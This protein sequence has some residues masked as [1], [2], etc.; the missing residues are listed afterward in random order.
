MLDGRY[1]R[2]RRRQRY[3]CYPPGTSHSFV[4]SVPRQ[5]TPDNQCPACERPFGS[6]REG[7]QG[8]YEHRYTAREIAQALIA[9]GRGDSYGHTARTLRREHGRYRRRGLT[10]YLAPDATLVMDWV[11]VFAPVLERALLAQSWP[12]QGL[13]QQQASRFPAVLVDDVPFHVRAWK[14]RDGATRT[15]KQS[16]RRIFAILGAAYYVGDRM[17][18]LRL[19]AVPTATSEARWMELL[20]IVPHQ[21]YPP[22][23]VLSDEAVGLSGAIRRV[24]PDTTVQ[25][26]CVYHLRAQLERI[27]YDAGLTTP[28]RR[29][30]FAGIRTAFQPPVANW[31]VWAARARALHIPRLHAWLRRKEQKVRRQVGWA[32][33]PVSSGA[34]ELALQKVKGMLDRRRWAYRNQKRMDRLLA[35]IALHLNE[36]DSEVVY[37][38][39]IRDHLASNRDLLRY[40]RAQAMRQLRVLPG[41]AAPH[42]GIAGRPV[43]ARHA[44]YDR[45]GQLASLRRA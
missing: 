45:R 34:L 2:E 13:F 33:W 26:L 1:G 22:P 30:V 21:G 32:Y 31:D 29:A 37:S 14:T 6:P 3:R 15:P 8:P 7:F 4:A 28:Q 38:Q 9:V 25:A 35:L 24:W 36:Q 44:V 41:R 12:A 23:V 18:I 43:L 39:L 11:E 17:R 20:R 40:T 5:G 10:R 16:G 27:L 19:H 42:R